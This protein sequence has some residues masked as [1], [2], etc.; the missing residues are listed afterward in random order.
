MKRLSTIVLALLLAVGAVG[1]TP[2]KKVAVVLS[3]GGAKGT[4]HISALRVIEEA[5]IPVDIVVGTSMGSIIGGLYSIGYTTAQLDSIVTSLDWG[6]LLSDRS[7]RST[8]NFMQK[9]QQ[10]TYAL[11]LPLTKNVK[12]LTSGGFVKGKNIYNKFIELTEGYHHIKDFNKFPRPFACVA[13]DIVKGKEIVFH[14]GELA[15]AMRASMSIP[16][17]FAP[18][19]LDSLVLVDGGMVNNYPVDI[20]KAM[21]ADIVIGVDVQSKFIKQENLKSVGNV[22]AQILNVLV[23]NKFEENKKL[24]DVYIHIPIKGFTAASFT[25]A[26]IDSIMKLG[27]IHSH[28]KWDE[29]VALKE[30]IGKD[31]PE[32]DIPIPPFQMP[33]TIEAYT[34]LLT[35]LDSIGM[36]N[37]RGSLN[38]GVRFDTEELAALIVNAN[39]QLKNNQKSEVAI[40]ARLGERTYGRLNYAFNP[41][42][43]TKVDLSYE[44]QHGN[45]NYNYNGTR[46][47]STTSLLNKIKLSFSSTWKKKF[48]VD[49]GAF[50]EHYNYKTIMI[51]SKNEAI[52]NIQKK[53]SL[54]TY[55]ATLQFNSYN[56]QSYPTQGSRVDME[57]ELITNNFVTYKGEAPISALSAQWES[58]IAL[59][60]RLTILPS[61]YGRVLLYKELPFSKTNFLG[62]EAHERYSPHQMAFSG[63]GGIEMVSPSIAVA[64]LRV[65]QRIDKSYYALLNMNYAYCTDVMKNID[66]GDNLFGG[67]VGAGYN[68]VLGPIEA[69][70]GYANRTSKVNFFLNVGYYF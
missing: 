19:H 7:E 42:K 47:Y 27:D 65:Q 21:G 31:E 70:L 37:E 41:G 35:N 17:A 46:L 8:L 50:Y 30:R 68:S 1:A 44:L 64:R 32:T 45:L 34:P 69:S 24:T 9:R 61:I 2:R 3:G 63:I 38:L 58:A 40:T 14:G 43:E 11:S 4:A 6:T 29:L 23:S 49:F 54:I 12:D 20:A 25:T 28:A 26:A 5:G 56:K 33:D 57:Y 16:A 59:N 60:D 53:E 62:G 66:F 10:E 13:F 18:V 22:A 15:T 51:S 48:K 67:S 52:P 39:I 55:Y 36:P